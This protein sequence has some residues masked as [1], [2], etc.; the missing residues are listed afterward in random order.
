MAAR[1]CSSLLGGSSPSVRQEMRRHRDAHRS[2]SSPSSPPSSR[3]GCG[4]GR[5]CSVVLRGWVRRRSDGEWAWEEEEDNPSTSSSS[6]PASSVAVAV[7]AAAPAAS[8]V[9]DP[10]V[11]RATPTLPSG[12]FRPKQSLGQNFLRDGNT[13]AKIVRAF[14]ADASSVDG[15]GGGGAGGGGGGAGGGG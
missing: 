1:P 11:A 12:S 7:A 8:A 13:V 5:T 6:S 4:G 10:L 9:V 2:S 14:V 15:C 3:G